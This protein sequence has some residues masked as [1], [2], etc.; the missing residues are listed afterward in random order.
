MVCNFPTVASFAADYYEIIKT[1]KDSLLLEYDEGN[2]TIRLKEN[3]K[4]VSTSC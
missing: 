3:A 2:E 4:A 1:L